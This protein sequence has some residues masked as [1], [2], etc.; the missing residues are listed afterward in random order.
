MSGGLFDFVGDIGGALINAKS[1]K[2]LAKRQDAQAL[3]DRIEQQREFDAQ[4]QSDRYAQDR[5]EAMFGAQ[6]TDKQKLD[7]LRQQAFEESKN[8][9]TGM[10]A[11]GDDQIMN[12]TA[13][14]MSPELQKVQSDIQSGTAEDIA[15][16]TGEMQKNLAQQGVRGGQAA[17]ALNRG[18]GTMRTTGM[19]DVNQMALDEANNK[20]AIR[21]AYMQNKALTGQKAALSP[22]TF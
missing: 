10:Y 3:Q 2:N 22:A 16:G 1:Q 14:G 20:K 8:M 13:A 12:E 6:M 15:R 7:Q 21:T 11:Q 9:G 19:R 4:Q 18:V 5:Q 17:T